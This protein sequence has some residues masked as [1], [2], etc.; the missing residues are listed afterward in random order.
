[1]RSLGSYVSHVLLQF[2]ASRDILQHDLEQCYVQQTCRRLQETINITVPPSLANE[3]T[4]TLLR[5]IEQCYSQLLLNNY[6]DVFQK[7]V[8]EVVNA[9]F[10]PSVTELEYFGSD[11]HPGLSD[12]SKLRIPTLLSYVALN[13]FNAVKVLRLGSSLLST[14][15]LKSILSALEDLQEFSYKWCCDEILEYLSVNCRRLKILD[16]SQSME[17]TDLSVDYILKFSCLEMLNVD[18]E[19][20]SETGITKL[21]EG[22][23]RSNVSY[24]PKCPVSPALLLNSFGC[25]KVIQ[26]HIEILVENFPNLRSLSLSKTKCCSLTALKGLKYLT[27]LTLKYF[28]LTDAKDV[29]QEMKGRFLY[30]ELG[31]I[32]ITDL[33]FVAENC[34]SLQCLHLRFC[35]YS[36]LGIPTGLSLVEYSKRYAV[37]ELKHV[38]CLLLDV[39]DPYFMEYI[40]SRCTSVKELHVTN[41]G[42]LSLFWSLLQREHLKSLDLFLW[43]R[44]PLETVLVQINER[45]GIIIEADGVTGKMSVHS[46]NI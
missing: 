13:K 18:C 2:S 12:V 29:I 41:G 36:C 3:L 27:K 25:N 14:D 35:P 34:H 21:L 4:A 40:V 1:M 16:I 30:L 5:C 39:D 42:S 17:V 37:P 26:S 20:V 33:I 43:K 46:V 28:S 31:H 44:K 10:H 38:H 32:D 6:N 23:A 8:P 7:A 24:I 19:G 45:R 9:V 22:F 15:T 11:S